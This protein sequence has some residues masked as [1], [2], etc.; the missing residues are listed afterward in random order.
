MRLNQESGFT[1]N[2][3][4]DLATALGIDLHFLGAQSHNSIGCRETYHELLRQVF[5]VLRQRYNNME[6]EV[7]LRYAVK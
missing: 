4:R 7:L 3:F 5:R 1:L 2:K 6:P